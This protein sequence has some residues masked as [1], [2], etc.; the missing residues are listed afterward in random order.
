MLTPKS[1]LQSNNSD[2]LDYIKWELF[3]L[4]LSNAT[5]EHFN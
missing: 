5:G 2:L 4:S 1:N 3:R